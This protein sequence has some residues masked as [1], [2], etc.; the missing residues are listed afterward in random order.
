MFN[1]IFK[2]A[3]SKGHTKVAIIE[4]RD[5]KLQIQIKNITE[6]TAEFFKADEIDK[7]VNFLN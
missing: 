1:K 2:L 7:I 6:N 4:T 3:E 5:G